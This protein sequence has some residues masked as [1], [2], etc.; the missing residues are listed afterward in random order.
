M[1]TAPTFVGLGNPE[2]AGV[3]LERPGGNGGKLRREWV[4]GCR[5]M[6]LEIIRYGVKPGLGCLADG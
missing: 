4:G 5:D 6:G 2:A 1:V 3:H